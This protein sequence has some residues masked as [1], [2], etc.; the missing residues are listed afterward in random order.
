MKKKKYIIY[1]LILLLGVGIYSIS[2]YSSYIRLGM[3]VYKESYSNNQKQPEEKSVVSIENPFYKYIEIV[4]D[5]EFTKKDG[6][7]VDVAFIN[8]TPQVVTKPSIPSENSS[9]SSNE[10]KVE[11]KEPE[12]PPFD[13]VASEYYSKF[14][15]L[16]NKLKEDLDSLI[17]DAIEDYNN[18]KYKKLRLAQVYL[19][20]GN[21]LEV[22][23]D[24]LFSATLKAMES[25]LERY[26]YDK[27]LV[28]EIEEYY[29]NN[30]K[31][32]K[33]EIIEKGMAILYGN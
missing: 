3:E 16:E 7:D 20:K 25:T 15:S 21:K 31:S 33:K 13:E 23:S 32:Q 2:E 11:D 17:D 28:Y 12:I 27:S 30:K 18:K 1:I 5:I 26:S 6:I 19:D 14:K 29:N 22:E 24:K 9:K 4:E 8:E 10:E